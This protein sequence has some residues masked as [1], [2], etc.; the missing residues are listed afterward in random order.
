MTEAE[1]QREFLEF[2]KI[3]GYTLRYHTHDARKSPKGFP[4]WMLVREPPRPRL[5]VV[6]LKGDSNRYGVQP[7]QQRWIDALTACGIE[8][9]VWTPA[10]LPQIPIILMR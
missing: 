10:D 6:E 7:E 9:Y 8:A 4:D 1:L 5:I 3:Y 2:A